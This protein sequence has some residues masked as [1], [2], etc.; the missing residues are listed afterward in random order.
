MPVVEHPVAQLLE[1]SG[2]P[3]TRYAAFDDR[4]PFAGVAKVMG[5]P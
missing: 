4:P 2:H 5:E 3:I 1:R